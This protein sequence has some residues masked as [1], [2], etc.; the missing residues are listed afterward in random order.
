VSDYFDEVDPANGTEPVNGN[1]I[2]P[3]PEAFTAPEKIGSVVGAVLDRPSPEPK[4]AALLAVI[5]SP[6]GHRLLV[7]PMLALL[8]P[9]DQPGEWDEWL[10]LL[11]G[12]ALELVSDGVEVDVDQARESARVVL[13]LLFEGAD[14]G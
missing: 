14:Q 8:P 2:P 1:G 10:G 13:G 3:M 11:A 5:A 7:R 12:C 6:L 9:L 4:V